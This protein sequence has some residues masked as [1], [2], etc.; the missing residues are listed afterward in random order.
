MVTNKIFLVP[1]LLPHLDRMRGK[2]NAPNFLF[3]IAGIRFDDNA[4]DNGFDDLL[5]FNNRKT[6]IVSIASTIPGKYWT[7]HPVT[8]AGVTGC[9]R[10]VPGYYPA[11]HVLGIHGAQYPDFKHEA[12]IQCGK[13]RYA[14]DTNKDGIIEDFEPVQEGYGK[15][16][17]IHRCSRSQIVQY[18]DKYSAGCQVSE[19]AAV[20]EAAVAMHKESMS[21]TA[22]ISYLLTTKEEWFELLDTENIRPILFGEVA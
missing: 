8:D 22:P 18:V 16:F 12:W 10:L 5:I 17:N 20:H 15:G 21:A 2:H 9:G 4:M 19:V 3:D 14:R 7:E 13:L 1:Q 11:S 6:A